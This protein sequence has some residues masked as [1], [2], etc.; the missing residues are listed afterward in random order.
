MDGTKGSVKGGRGEVGNPPRIGLSHGPD[1]AFSSAFSAQSFVAGATKGC[2]RFGFQFHSKSFGWTV[3]DG[4]G[5]R[6]LAAPPSLLAVEFPPFA[7]ADASVPSVDHL[8][9]TIVSFE[10]TAPA[11]CAVAGA[12]FPA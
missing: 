2:A 10:V 3:T 7:G 6:R 4:T 5:R 1:L 12:C 9:D 11:V 8:P